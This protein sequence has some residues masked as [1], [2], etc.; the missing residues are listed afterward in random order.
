MLEAVRSGSALA[1]LLPS[2]YIPTVAFGGGCMCFIHSNVTG[3]QGA[4]R[5][6]RN[7]D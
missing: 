2:K 4:S 6:H 1:N 7:F 3:V 5:V